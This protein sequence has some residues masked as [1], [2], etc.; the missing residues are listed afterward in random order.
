MTE[1]VADSRLPGPAQP[2]AEWLRAA[3]RAKALSWLSLVWMGLEGGIA[4]AAGIAAGSIALIGFG[5]DSA[6]E[7][8]ASVVI[9]W[10]FTGD[11]YAL[12]RSRGASAEAGGDPVLHP[13]SLR[14]LRGD[15]A[16]HR[17]RASRGQPPGN[18]IDRHQRG[19]N[20]V[21]GGSKAAG[22][23]SARLSGHAR[24]R[25]AEPALRVLGRGRLPRP[26]RQRPIRCLVATIRSRLWRSPASQSRRASRPGEGKAAAPALPSIPRTRYAP[27]IATE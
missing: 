13:R 19:R 23:T 3:H 15:R 22:R 26:R 1:L 2:S 6:I 18:G 9:I 5:I 10:R 17:W 12:P 27:T 20:A 7:G 24:G 25:D 16:S 8:A 11:P 14:R 4:I 21:I